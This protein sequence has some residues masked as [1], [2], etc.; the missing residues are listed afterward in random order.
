[1]NWQRLGI[2]AAIV[3]A[4]AAVW[5]LMRGQPAVT[6]NNSPN[7]SGAGVVPSSQTG[8]APA[9]YTL[10]PSVAAPSPALSLNAPANPAST[11]TVP[12]DQG[13]QPIHPG[14]YLSY[15]LGPGAALTKG[16]PI[17]AISTASAP[18]A[19][20]GQSCGCDSGCSSCKNNGQAV[21]AGQGKDCMATSRKRQIDALEKKYPGLWDHM[22]DN[23][24]EAGV[25]GMELFAPT[26]VGPGSP[27]DSSVVSTAGKSNTWSILGL[28]GHA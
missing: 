23:L 28:V 7:P 15:N 5:A 20:C 22:R 18:V 19:S 12:A 8:N 21:D 26:A 11:A 2:I 13:P 1:M 25:D 10:N 14:S 17:Q 24:Q 9:A 6:V 3:A 27:K 16:K 4:V